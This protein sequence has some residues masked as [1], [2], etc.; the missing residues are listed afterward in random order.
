MSYDGMHALILK[1]IRGGWGG[2]GH[3]NLIWLSFANDKII[4]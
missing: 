3:Q 2:G 1:K 4:Y